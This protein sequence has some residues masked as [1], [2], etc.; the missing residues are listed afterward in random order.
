LSN[1]EEKCLECHDLDNSPAF[2]EEG[3]FDRYW[4]KI[5]L[6]RPRAASRFNVS[7]RLRVMATPRLLLAG[8]MPMIVRGLWQ[9]PSVVA[10]VVTDTM[11]PLATPG[12]RLDG[13]RPPARGGAFLKRDE[14]L[15]G[16]AISVTD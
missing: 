5:A 10:F 15:K 8:S 14:R 12:R 16:C 7:P 2:Q 6:G 13:S 11:P 1:A 9:L 4:E 3:A